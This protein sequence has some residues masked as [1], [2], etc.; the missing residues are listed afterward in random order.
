MNPITKAQLD[1]ISEQLDDTG[2]PRLLLILPESAGDI[3]LA[4]SLFAS[5]KEAYPTHDMYFACQETF[6]DIL[7]NNPYIY[8]VIEYSIPMSNQ[9]LMEGTG[10]WSGLFDISIFLSGYTQLYTNY[11][12]NG[13]TKILLPLKREKHASS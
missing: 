5:L 1:L 10:S 7:K 9:I 6:F 8:K 3:L 12:N 2:S 4:T 11:L 13:K